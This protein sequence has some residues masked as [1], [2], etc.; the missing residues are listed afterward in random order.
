MCISIG[1]SL[2]DMVQRSKVR[3]NIRKNMI[4]GGM[5]PAFQYPN[6]RQRSRR[7]A[8][9][10][11]YHDKRLYLV[12][13]AA[14]PLRS[15]IARPMD[16]YEAASAE[17]KKKEN[18]AKMLKEAQRKSEQNPLRSEQKLAVSKGMKYE[19][20]Y[21]NYLDY[22]TLQKIIGQ[23]SEDKY[24]SPA[25]KYTKP[26]LPRTSKYDKDGYDKYGYDINHLDKKGYDIHGNYWYGE[27]GFDKF[28]LDKDGYDE[29]GYNKDGFNEDGLDDDGYGV[30]REGITRLYKKLN[31]DYEDGIEGYYDEDGYNQDGYNKYGF[32]EDGF[33][34]DGYGF[35]KDGREKLYKD[36]YD[37]DGYNKDGFDIHGYD[38]GGYNEDGYDEDGYDLDGYKEDG[39]N[40]DGFNEDGFNKDGYDEDGFNED[41][42]NKDGF[43]KGENEA[44]VPQ[45]LKLPRPRK[46]STAAELRAARAKHGLTPTLAWERIKKK[47]ADPDPP[48]PHKPQKPQK[49]QESQKPQEQVLRARI[50]TLREEAMKYMEEGDYPKST[51][52]THEAE[53]LTKRLQNSM[54][55]VD[56][57]VKRVSSLPAAEASPDPIMFDESLFEDSDSSTD[58]EGGGLNKRG[59]RKYT[60]RTRHI[61]ERSK[62]KRSKAKRMRKPKRKKTNRKS[63]TR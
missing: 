30:D 51:E 54:K 3:R 27:D 4:R 7:A 5:D 35:D 45:A 44:L 42:F 21:L 36:G 17:E 37:E 29:D 41:G 46:A 8:A 26:V 40:K 63:Q 38:D 32:N 19:D 10:S 14:S 33:D 28:G 59:R 15:R 49:P 50:L 31:T 48:Q 11:D 58:D 60:R 23:V 55:K 52:K 18:Y 43:N 20:S 53:V 16:V 1:M 22:D 34:K 57:T 9:V 25:Q 39:F 6:E 12:P 13:G 2:D 47:S 24:R 61:R 62:A 56:D